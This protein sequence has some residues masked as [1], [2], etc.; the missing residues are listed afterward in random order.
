MLPIIERDPLSDRILALPETAGERLIDDYDLRRLARVTALEKAAP[1]QR[2]A[3]GLE[4]IFAADQGKGRGGRRVRLRITMF[5]CERRRIIRESVQ[6]KA[7]RDCD[8]FHGRQLP[9]FVQV[10]VPKIEPLLERVV[11]GEVEA[12]AR[13]ENMICVHAGIDLVQSHQTARS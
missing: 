8:R 1:E 2:L 3:D 13:S 9:N 12:E 10:S 7:P 4:I 11:L 5:D 6:W